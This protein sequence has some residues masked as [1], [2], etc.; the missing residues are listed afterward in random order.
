[1]ILFT[2]VVY[3]LWHLNQVLHPTSYINILSNVVHPGLYA[4]WTKDTMHEESTN[5]PPRIIY[6][7]SH[8]GLDWEHESGKILYMSP[9]K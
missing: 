4:S 5:I 3:L 1:M 7:G 6:P 9:G 8:T 2:I